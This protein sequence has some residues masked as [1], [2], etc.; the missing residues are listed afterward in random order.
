MDS[1]HTIVTSRPM[2]LKTRRRPRVAL[3]VAMLAL[4]VQ[5]LVPP[6]HLVAEAMAGAA[7]GS[8]LVVLCTADG[9]RVVSLADL[10][11]GAPEPAGAEHRT[12][13]CVLCVGHQAGDPPL[14]PGTAAPLAI[15]D[16]S[17]VLNASIAARV[18]AQRRLA[19]GSPRG[20]PVLA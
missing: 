19:P 18:V 20:P 17:V 1:I 13:A 12:Q 9:P 15:D 6:L 7:F 16:S 14:L 3:C 11:A 2:R 8:R 4:L 5:T 10:G